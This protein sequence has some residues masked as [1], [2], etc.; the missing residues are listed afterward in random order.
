MRSSSE[1]EIKELAKFVY[2]A[3][4]QRLHH[5]KFLCN[6]PCLLCDYVHDSYYVALR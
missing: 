2:K 4:Q 6:L 1:V 3:F 5:V